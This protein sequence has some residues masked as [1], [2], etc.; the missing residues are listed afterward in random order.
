M[1]PT[2]SVFVLPSSFKSRMVTP[3][4]EIYSFVY[5]NKEDIEFTEPIPGDI[6]GNVSQIRFITALIV[7]VIKES[8]QFIGKYNIERFF[9][10]ETGQFSNSLLKSRQLFSL[11]NRLFINSLIRLVMGVFF[12]WFLV[13]LFLLRILLFL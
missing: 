13:E 7:V 6:Q 8:G 11:I 9:K 4:K 12:L 1:M 10:P 3:C 5:K 2:I